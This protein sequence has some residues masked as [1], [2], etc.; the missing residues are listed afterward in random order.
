MQRKNEK[1]CTNCQVH[2]EKNKL[3]ESQISKRES[4]QAN[5]DTDSFV[6]RKTVPELNTAGIRLPNFKSNL[7]KEKFLEK[8]YEETNPENQKYQMAKSSFNKPQ[9]ISKIMKNKNFAQSEIPLKSFA[10]SP[11]AP[12]RTHSISKANNNRR[13]SV[14]SNNSMFEN[15]VQETIINDDKS[16]N[17]MSEINQVYLQQI[18]ETIDE[19]RHTNELSNIEKFKMMKEV[20]S[21]YKEL[22]N[23]N[24]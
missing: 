15:L 5:S 18:K 11:M 10:F 21:E 14:L 16:L 6:S 1:I 19:I 12:Q 17:L 7:H 20:M 22:V 8:I 4:I 24:N 13:S 2:K 3:R 23:S 9:M